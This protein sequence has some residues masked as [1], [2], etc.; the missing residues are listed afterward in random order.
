MSSTLRLSRG[1]IAAIITICVFF[2]CLPFNRTV[3]ADGPVT[4]YV[5]IEE[6]G[7]NDRFYAKTLNLAHMGALTGSNDIEEKDKSKE[8]GELFG[9]NSELNRIQYNQ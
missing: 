7:E 6:D 3:R 2:T 1:F 8:L 9:I 5:H 4:Y